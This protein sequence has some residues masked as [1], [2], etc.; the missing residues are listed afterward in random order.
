MVTSQ[1][2]KTVHY[3]VAPATLFFCRILD[4]QQ[5]SCYNVVIRQ[6]NIMSLTEAFSQWENIK[7]DLDSGMSVNQITKKYKF[8]YD[9]IKNVI[10]ENSYSYDRVQSARDNFYSEE[11]KNRLL[12][13]RKDHTVAEI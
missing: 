13:L 6:V 12:D 7:S 1:F 2:N 8:S 11:Y 4:Y 3:S 5:D 9:T 10:D